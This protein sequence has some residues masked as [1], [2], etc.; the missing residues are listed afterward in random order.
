MMKEEILHEW[1]DRLA[2]SMRI[3]FNFTSARIFKEKDPLFQEPIP[4]QLWANI[5]TFVQNLS[6]LPLWK[7]VEL[8]I[9]SSKENYDSWRHIFNTGQAKSGERILAEPLNINTLILPKK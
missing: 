6:D 5:E 8:Q 4:E 3:Y 9:F 1:L 2:E 7:N